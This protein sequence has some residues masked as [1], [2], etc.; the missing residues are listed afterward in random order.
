MNPPTCK[1]IIQDGNKKIIKRIRS[2]IEELIKEETDWKHGLFVSKDEVNPLKDKLYDIQKLAMTSD[3]RSFS[4]PK[5]RR[6]SRLGNLA[7][8]LTPSPSISDDRSA[9]PV[10]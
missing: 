4:R 1:Q 5:S 10:I 3:F 8:L 2:K 6:K 9:R 7:S